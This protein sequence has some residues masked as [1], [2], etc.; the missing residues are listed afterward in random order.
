MVMFAFHNRSQLL[1]M[2]SFFAFSVSYHG[3]LSSV[4]I[5]R[6]IWYKVKDSE[7]LRNS[8]QL[9]QSSLVYCVV[10]L[11]LDMLLPQFVVVHNW[12]AN[13]INDDHSQQ[14]N[15]NK[16]T[17]IYQQ[18]HCKK[19]YEGADVVGSINHDFSDQ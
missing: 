8:S 1:I 15:T 10:L 7:L 11:L 14:S 13:D 16:N 6:A 12:K 18:V 9:M 3:Q 5:F 2:L 19:Y 4:S 17:F